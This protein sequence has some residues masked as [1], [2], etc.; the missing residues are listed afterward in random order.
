MD[1][2]YFKEEIGSE[3][4]ARLQIHT[5]TYLIYRWYYGWY[6]QVCVHAKVCLPLCLYANDGIFVL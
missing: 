4:I 5:H 1:S 2:I 6:I 3:E